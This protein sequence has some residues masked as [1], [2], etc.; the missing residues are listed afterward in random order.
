METK[1]NCSKC[2]ACCK[3]IPDPVLKIYGL[4]RSKNGGCG[5]LLADNS[6]SIYDARPDVCNVKI[7]WD[8]NYSKTVTWD[9]YKK[10]SEELCT[11]MMKL[12][13]DKNE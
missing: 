2:G 6:C 10:I 9:D 13:E 5:H 11:I 4:P 12:N 1:F 8:K 3:L 7:M